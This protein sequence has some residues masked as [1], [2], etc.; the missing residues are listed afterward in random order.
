MTKIYL[1][2]PLFSEGELAYNRYIKEQVLTALPEITLHLPQEVESINDKE[3]YADSVMIA[4]ADTQAV[5]ESQLV[6]AVLDGLVIDPGVASEIGIAFQAGIPVIGLYTDSRQQ[7][8]T[9]P[10]KIAALQDIAES[11]FSYINLYT[12]GLV[13]QNGCVVNSVQA[14][15]DAIPNYISQEKG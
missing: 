1:A 8:G 4:Q 7:G 5:L 12:V 3:A 15:I 2:S 9:H 14:V 11:Q 13:K 10:K 6:I